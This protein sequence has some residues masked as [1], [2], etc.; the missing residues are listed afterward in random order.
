MLKKAFL[1]IVDDCSITGYLMNIFMVRT[2]QKM[3]VGEGV[4]KKYEMF[5]QALYLFV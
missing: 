4:I 2:T 5:K 3:R 1:N